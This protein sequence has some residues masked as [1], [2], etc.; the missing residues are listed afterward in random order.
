MPLA[1]LNQCR[2]ESLRVA[3]L[4]IPWVSMA[5]SLNSN[6][7][8]RP[9]RQQWTAKPGIAAENSGMLE[10]CEFTMQL[11]RDRGLYTRIEDIARH[12]TGQ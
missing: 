4:A 9:D 3:T 2:V 10:S 1:V 11:L 8:G 6:P 5:R 12:R 7:I